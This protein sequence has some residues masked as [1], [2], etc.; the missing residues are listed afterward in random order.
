MDIKQTIKDWML[1]IA[2]VT[3][4]SLYLIY[5][6]LPEPVHKAG[7]FLNGLVEVMQPLLIFAMLFLTFCRI[8][9]KELRPHR[10]HWWLLLIQG[11]LFTVLGLGTVLAVRLLPEGSHEWKVLVESAMLCLIC[12]TATAAAVVTRKLGGDVPGITTYIVL[13]NIVAAILV[14]LIV[15]LIQPMAGL[16]FW[17]AF[18]M[19]L[20]KVLPLLMLPCFCAWLVRYLMPKVHKKLLEW[21]DLPFNLWVVALVLAIAVTTKA[22]VKSEMSWTLIGAMAFISLICCVLQFAAGRYVGG[23]YKPRRTD[24]SPEVELRGR[25][26]RKVTAGQSLGQKNTVFAIWLGYT[27][28]TPETAIVGGLYSIWHNIYNSWQLYRAE[29]A[30]T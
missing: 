16:T 23:R 29:N 28:M 18:N 30:G 3:G 4:A 15:P 24:V 10:W 2:M 12:P 17:E 11:G 9:P 25:E 8:E 27:F 22:I 6:A 19:I 14:P 13:I 20:A 21:Q 5:N 1:P 26:V 7:P